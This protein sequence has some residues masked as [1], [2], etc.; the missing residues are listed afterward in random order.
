V[1]CSTVNPAQGRGQGVLRAGSVQ[2]SQC[3]D[4]HTQW[5]V[6][7]GLVSLAEVQLCS[8]PGA[9]C[10]CDPRVESLLPGWGPAWLSTRDIWQNCSLGHSK[11]GCGLFQ[12]HGLDQE[13]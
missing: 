12:G 6:L 2:A 8:D 1:T 7:G 5:T 9:I 3:W 11:L 10:Q 13:R 4:S